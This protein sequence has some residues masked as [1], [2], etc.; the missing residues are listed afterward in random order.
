MKTSKVL[1]IARKYVAN[2]GYICWSL[3]RALSD[4]KIPCKDFIRVRDMV[5]GR[6]RGCLSL[7]HWLLQYHNIKMVRGNDFGANFHAY[8]VKIQATRQAWLN[9]MIDEFRSK[10]D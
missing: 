5:Q 7:E 8:N 1:T 6:L 2:E 9:S 4:K 3:Q 10:K